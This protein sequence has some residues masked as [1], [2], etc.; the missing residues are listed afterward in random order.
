MLGPR[1]PDL[2]SYNETLRS[3]GSSVKSLYSKPYAGPLYRRKGQPIPSR[4]RAGFEQDLVRLRF[5]G[6]KDAEPLGF[7][8]GVAVIC[9]VFERS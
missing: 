6:T 9:L 7:C 5:T 3:S 1:R 4:G 2:T 8:Q